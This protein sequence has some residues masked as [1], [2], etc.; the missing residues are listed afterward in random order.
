M[1]CD[2]FYWLVFYQHV[3]SNGTKI[4]EILGF[5]TSKGKDSEIITRRFYVTA[6]TPET[7][8]TASHEYIFVNKY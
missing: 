2:L 7:A 4:E 5:N 6:E 3:V 8:K 1:G